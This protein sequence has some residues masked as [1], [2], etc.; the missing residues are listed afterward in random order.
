MSQQILD[1]IKILCKNIAKVEW[2][3]VLFYSVQGSIR[4]PQVFKI[5]LE[6]ILPLDMGTKAYTEYELDDRFTDFLMEEP[7]RMEWKVGHIHSHND[8]SV[9]FS[10]T[11]VSELKDNCVNHNY[12]LSLIVNNF[13]DFQA[14]IAFTGELT[15]VVKDVPYQSL[16][17]NGDSYI[18]SK[19]DLNYTKTKMFTYDC[20]IY[21]PE[22]RLAVSDDFMTRVKEIMKPKPVAV[23]PAPKVVPFIPVAQSLKQTPEQLKIINKVKFGKVDKTK[24]TP[25]SKILD[26]YIFDIPFDDYEDLAIDDTIS[27]VELFIAETMKVGSIL[28]AGENLEDVLVV[29]EDLALDSYDYAKTVLEFYGDIYDKYFP[30]SS[31]EDFISTSDEACDLLY[32]VIGQFPFINVTIKAIEAMLIKFKENAAAT[33]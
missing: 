14:K 32:D 30:D 21:A 3:G 28:E 12:Y 5:T 17:E 33:I 11:D 13:M 22:E 19:T 20:D 9:F 6:D 29:I 27:M 18:L 26:A 24:L 7:E 10:P 2:S 8:M 16:D 1:K 15:K 23:I 31:D 25:R 4:T